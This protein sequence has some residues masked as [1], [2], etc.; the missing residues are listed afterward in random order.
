MTQPTNDNPHGYWCKPCGRSR[1][2]AE[3]GCSSA[4]CRERREEEDRERDEPRPDYT[5]WIMFG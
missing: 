2:H 5:K 4:A 3:T 1:S